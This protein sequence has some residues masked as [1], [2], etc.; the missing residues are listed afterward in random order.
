M[1]EEPI[2]TLN[3]FG[4]SSP[5]CRADGGER[6]GGAVE[7][8]GNM[9]EHDIAPNSSKESIDHEPGES[10]EQQPRARS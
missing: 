5:P 7:R 6:L 10:V 4:P 2:A 1:T 3:H 9:V 8:V